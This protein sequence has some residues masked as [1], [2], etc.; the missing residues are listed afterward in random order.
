MSLHTYYDALKQ[1]PLAKDRDNATVEEVAIW[2]EMS[3]NATT[4]SIM[5]ILKAIEKN[6]HVVNVD[7]IDVGLAMLASY[8]RTSSPI[9]R[10]LHFSDN[11]FYWIF[12]IFDETNVLDEAML[13]KKFI[14]YVKKARD[15]H[16]K[17]ITSY[18]RCGE[19]I[20][21]SISKRDE[22]LYEIFAELV[23]IIEKKLTKRHQSLQT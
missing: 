10:R 21:M 4:T 20:N 22:D 8:A 19:L 11:A 6:Y 13:D 1:T 2:L 12:K 5:R 16:R 7:W 15:T 9:L 18:K 23:D 14:N 17:K 3:D